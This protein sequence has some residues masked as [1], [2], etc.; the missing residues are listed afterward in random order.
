MATFGV[1]SHSSPIVI[2]D[3]EDEAY[4]EL[5]LEQRLSSPRD[6]LFDDDLQY[7]YGFEA[8]VAHLAPHQ[9]ESYLDNPPHDLAPNAR[10]VAGASDGNLV[11]Q[12]RRRDGSPTSPEQHTPAQPLPARPRSPSPGAPL[13]ESKRARKKRRRTELL[14]A[15]N[16]TQHSIALSQQNF[17]M[18]GP[19]VDV[20]PYIPMDIPGLSSL[21]QLNPIAP[22]FPALPFIHPPYLPPK[23]M[24]YQDFPIPIPPLPHPHMHFLPHIPMYPLPPPIPLPLLPTPPLPPAIPTMPIVPNPQPEAPPLASLP[25]SAPQNAVPTPD[26]ARKAAMPKKVIGMTPDADPGSH[27]GTYTSPSPTFSPPNP[28]RTLVMEL[29]PK[30]FRT[31]AFVRGWAS[32]FGPY[33]PRV[34]LNVKLGKA[35][36]EFP[37]A[38]VA[39]AAWES[40]RLAGDGKEH[41]RLWWY[42]V[43]GIGADAGVGE[44][45]EGEIEDGEIQVRPM[46]QKSDARLNESNKRV[47]NVQEPLPPKP[48]VKVKTSTSVSSSSTLPTAISST[49]SSS[50]LGSPVDSNT[51]HFPPFL[52]ATLPPKPFSF[53]SSSAGP[54]PALPAATSQA[55]THTPPNT[56]ANLPNGKSPLVPAFSPT[57]SSV[58]QSSVLQATASPFIP[59]SRTF[60]TAVTPAASSV[61]PPTCDNTQVVP[62][63]QIPTKPFDIQAGPETLTQA[64]RRTISAVLLAHSN[65]ETEGD[66]HS[67]SSSRPGSPA[68]VTG[69]LTLRPVPSTSPNL[70]HAA[71]AVPMTQS[72]LTTLPSN[73]PAVLSTPPMSTTSSSESRATRTPLK[74]P[75]Q[76]QQKKIEEQAAQ[77][78]PSSGTATPVSDVEA[79]LV[80]DT[81]STSKESSPATSAIDTASVIKESNLR[82]LVLSSMRARNAS[83]GAAAPGTKSYTATVT[84]SEIKVHHPKLSLDD[85]AT[86]FITQSIQAATL[87]SAADSLAL[88]S[89]IFSE[90]ALLSAK[91]HIL[92]RNIADQKGL[93]VQY[94][95]ARTKADRDRLKA[96]M[97]ERSRAMEHE[98]DAITARAQ[99]GK[100]AA[101]ALR[102]KW[103]ETDRNACILVLSDDEGED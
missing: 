88:V 28:A 51:R 60:S 15:R 2:S 26:N 82:Q 83:A 13:G 96:A 17:A 77:S 71:S 44:I 70:L 94:V 78:P 19:P 50:T 29:L 8:T 95:G 46:V 42:R 52:H 36:I 12:K 61:S 41:I 67:I 53:S 74:I 38:D 25:G 59:R 54:I 39:R 1:G 76:M 89:P 40:D 35:L 20:E 68:P 23:P 5:E 73:T 62:A 30:K 86:S 57:A 84:V 49:A 31:Q 45:E 65:Q 101:R 9:S 93:M 72:A 37:S 58:L 33:S 3:D 18:G 24:T 22:S 69:A 34:D 87:P 7:G 97:A 43:P 11:G 21:T 55:A 16:A 91:Q 100:E 90:K 79:M 66:R 4:V 99:A 64:S 10:Y 80:D 32:N 48:M 63:T 47:K 56:G 103:P 85:M 6:M 102:F 27:H 92:E 75:N 14:E 81:S 98:M